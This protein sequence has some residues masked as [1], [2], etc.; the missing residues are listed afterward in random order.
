LS[1]THCAQGWWK[2]LVTTRFGM[3]AGSNQQLLHH[4]VARALAP[5]PQ[6]IHEHLGV[7]N[8]FTNAIHRL[9]FNQVRSICGNGS[10]DYGRFM[11][12]RYE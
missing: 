11:A 7:H 5:S 2:K 6:W 9:S 12:N 4:P 8:F 10:V 3:P 1:P